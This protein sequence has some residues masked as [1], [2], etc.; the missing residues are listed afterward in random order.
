MQDVPGRLRVEHALVIQELA[1]FGDVD[2]DAVGCGRRRVLAP[3]RIHDAIA[4]HHSI[5][6]EQ[7]QCENAALLDAA[8]RY[9]TAVAQDLQRA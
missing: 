5:S 9:R 3:E 2:L 6:L 7:K 4:R 1:Q 8:Q